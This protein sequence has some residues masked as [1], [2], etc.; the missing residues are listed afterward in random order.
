M[1]YS[2]D[3]RQ[4][5]SIRP[6]QLL[7]SRASADSPVIRPEPLAQN[8]DLAPDT[9]TPVIMDGFVFGNHGALVCLDLEDELKTLWE[10]YE[11]DS[12]TQYCSFIAGNGHV[13]VTAQTGEVYLIRADKNA[14]NCVGRLSLFEDVADTDRE[15]WSHPALVG[16]RLYIRNL[17]AVYCFLLR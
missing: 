6:I 13:L 16:N 14:Y 10:E 12:L 4:K 15:V 7:L 8:E 2:A 1:T 17:L 5:L 9:S 3:Q 11:D